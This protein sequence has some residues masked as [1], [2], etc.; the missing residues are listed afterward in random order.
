MLK[1]FVLPVFGLFIV[2]GCGPV[3]YQP[4]PIAY[5][6]MPI[7]QQIVSYDSPNPFMQSQTYQ[8]ITV[9]NVTQSLTLQSTK[10][11]EIAKNENNA[12]S[13]Q[14][15]P[16]PPQIQLAIGASKYLSQITNVSYEQCNISAVAVTIK[17]Q[18]PQPVYVDITQFSA[19]TLMGEV[20]PYMPIDVASIAMNSEGFN[21]ALRGAGEGAVVGAAG[22]ALL[23]GLAAVA[24]GLKFE[25]GARLGAVSGGIGGVGGGA[26]A[27]R[28][29]LAQS[30]ASEIESKKFISR[31]I[32]P[33]TT[34][35]G[36]L[37]FPA[38]ISELKLHLPTKTVDINLAY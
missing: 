18:S 8:Q 7:Q 35:T 17:N 24:L 30:L 3:A 23:G 37:F 27:Y 19:T 28:Q 29:Q 15:Q 11:Q 31:N 38:G 2:Q 32:Y 33:N 34:F 13:T 26:T 21:Q 1:K 14:I 36:V 5:N 22:G 16:S 6:N 9:P 20:Q 25:H 12:M 10:A 4:R